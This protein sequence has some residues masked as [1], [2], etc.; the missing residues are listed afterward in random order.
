M[1]DYQ[2]DYYGWTVEQ[3]ELLK[4]G[5]WQDV[6]IANLIEEIESMGR[7]EKRSLESRLMVLLT[8]LLK[9]QYQPVRRGKSWELTIKGQRVNCLDVL[10]DNPSLKSKLDELF[11]KSYYRAKLEAAKETGLDEDFFPEACPYTLKQVF[12][13]TYYPD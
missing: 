11:A 2:T 10:D 3:A 9:W 8:H 13:N 4:S 12:D 5:L 1:I 7:S 6:D